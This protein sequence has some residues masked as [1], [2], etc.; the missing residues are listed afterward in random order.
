LEELS[1]QNTPIT[2]Q[3]EMEE[4]HIFLEIMEDS[5]QRENQTLLRVL[6]THLL[7]GLWVLLLIENKY[8]Q[9]STSQMVV[10]EILMCLLIVVVI[11]CQYS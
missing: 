5:A 1:I 2:N 10:E 3:M 8:G 4:I 7:C 6:G 11:M 9:L